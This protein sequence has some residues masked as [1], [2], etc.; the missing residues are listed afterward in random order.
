MG[1]TGIG[2]CARY[3]RDYFHQIEREKIEQV[4]GNPWVICTLWHVLLS[5]S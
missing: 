1:K 2:G 5:I 4:P 3:E